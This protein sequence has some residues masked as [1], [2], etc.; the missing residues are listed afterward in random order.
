M[1][2]SA[3]VGLVVFGVLVGVAALAWVPRKRGRQDEIRQD[4]LDGLA[5]PHVAAQHAMGYHSRMNQGSGN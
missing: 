1:N 5:D 2:A 3:I 4:D